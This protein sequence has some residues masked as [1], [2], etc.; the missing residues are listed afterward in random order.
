MNLNQN[1]NAMLQ[2]LNDAVLHLEKAVGIA[3]Q[4][5][6]NNEENI[7]KATPRL[8]SY[9]KIVERQKESLK[10]L[11]G[12]I[13]EKKFEDVIHEMKTINALSEMVREDARD[14]LTSLFS[15]SKEAAHI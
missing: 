15:K 14:L 4:A 9:E 6:A 3:K 7:R 11:S 10:K 2:R 1:S 13:S 12:L 8:D 5:I